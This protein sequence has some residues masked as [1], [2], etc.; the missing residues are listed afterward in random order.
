MIFDLPADF[1]CTDEELHDRFVNTYEQ[2]EL[3][4]AF[5]SIEKAASE[6]P[7]LLDRY[8]SFVSSYSTKK[9]M[10]GFDESHIKA[11]TEIHA[12]YVAGIRDRH[13]AIRELE[14]KYAHALGRTGMACCRSG[15][16]DFEGPSRTAIARSL[17]YVRRLASVP[18]HLV[19]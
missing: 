16:T 9:P 2:G 4:T 15:D 12:R 13:K 5:I 1:D 19:P 3:P 18:C 17:A 10:P 6:Y 14:H 8:H 11:D 7:G